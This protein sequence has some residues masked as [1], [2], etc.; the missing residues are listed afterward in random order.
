MGIFAYDLLYFYRLPAG[1]QETTSV[2]RLVTHS[3]VRVI[4]ELWLGGVWAELDGLPLVLCIYYA[5]MLESQTKGRKQNTVLWLE[6][7]AEKGDMK[8]IT[9]CM[10]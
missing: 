2:F 10:V 5:E 6:Q 4:N 8:E 3:Q 7:M 9:R 1:V